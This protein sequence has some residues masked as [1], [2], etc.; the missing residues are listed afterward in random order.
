M[1]QEGGIDVE[2]DLEMLHMGYEELVGNVL[3]FVFV[4]LMGSYYFLQCM[5]QLYWRSHKAWR[6]C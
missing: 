3:G 1:G 2:L 5:G 4:Y 6:V